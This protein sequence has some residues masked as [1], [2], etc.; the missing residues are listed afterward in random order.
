[1]AS[2]GRSHAQVAS[3][4]LMGLIVLTM[5]LPVSGAAPPETVIVAKSQ[6]DPSVKA[7]A[8][9]A[10][11]QVKAILILL[12]GGNGR[13]AI[14]SSGQP[15]QLSGNFLVRVRKD[16]ASYGFVTM[17]MDAAND[18]QEPPFLHNRYRTTRAHAADVAAVISKARATYGDK[19]TF[20]IGV[21]GSSTGA[22]NAARRIHGLNGAI[23]LN[24]NTLQNTE[25]FTPLDAVPLQQVNAPMLF[26]HHIED[27]C[28]YSPY[29][30][31]SAIYDALRAA[32]R[33]VALQKIDGGE[34]AP[35][36][37][38]CDTG[39]GHHGFRGVE[40]VVV[41]AIVSWLVSQLQ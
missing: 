15:T 28:Q 33:S 18:L 24:S 25:G 7:I 3:I 5:V 11:G 4:T 9:P 19:P 14:S 29:Q 16:F 41:R 40:Q 39:T 6:R 23:F 26:V 21:S 27:E 30:P 17:L 37:N 10:Q 13:L 35:Q 2:L 1:M 31:I 38:T 22:A 12:P 8:N 34:A 32:G 36:D 20:I